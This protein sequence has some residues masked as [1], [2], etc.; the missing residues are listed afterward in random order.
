MTCSRATLMGQAALPTFRTADTSAS[1]AA[2]VAG[3]GFCTHHGRRLAVKVYSSCRWMHSFVVCTY[4]IA[5]ARGKV[6]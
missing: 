5:G 3:T 4:K 2:F 1:M 6:W